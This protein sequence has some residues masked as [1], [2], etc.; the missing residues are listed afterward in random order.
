MHGGGWWPKCMHC[1]ACICISAVFNNLCAHRALWWNEMESNRIER[2][3]YSKTNERRKNADNPHPLPTKQMT[4]S[5]TDF[6]CAKQKA[7]CKP[8]KHP[9][10]KMH[11][12]LTDFR[13]IFI[14]TPSTRTIANMQTIF[15]QTKS[16]VN[17]KCV[18][19]SMTVMSKK[20]SLLIWN[21]RSPTECNATLSDCTF[22]CLLWNER[23][24]SNEKHSVVANKTVWSIN[25]GFILNVSS[26]QN[27]RTR[28]RP[29]IHFDSNIFFSRYK[30]LRFGLLHSDA[31]TFHF[32]SVHIATNLQI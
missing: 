13:F 30:W 18:H 12:A 2:G 23:F 21:F 11:A 31:S 19:L 16:K 32:S 9:L 29:P 20:N 7:R 22:Y 24:V 27:S 28:Y 17:N 3:E 26:E 1:V 6:V 25:F 10:T 15:F 4:E 8:E 14:C 5:H